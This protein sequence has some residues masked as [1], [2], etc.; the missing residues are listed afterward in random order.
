M[1]K[2]LSDLL[3]GL[4][5]EVK[6]E[7]KPVEVSGLAYDSRVAGSGDLFFCVK[8][9]RDDGHRYLPD[10]ERNGAVAS[11]VE[12]FVDGVGIP[13]FRVGDVRLAMSEVSAR[14]YDHPSDALS[15]I[16]I[17]GTKGKTTTTF[18]ME[19]ILRAAGYPS[20]LIGTIAYRVGKKLVKA[21]RTTP[22]AVDLQRML[23]DAVESGLKYV[24]MEVS[25][26]S[27][28][29]HR[30][31]SVRFAASLL[32]NLQPEHL[33]FHGSMD[34]YIAAKSKL[35]DLTEGVIVVNRD[36]EYFDAVLKRLGKRSFHTYSLNGKGDVNARVLRM[37]DGGVSLKV[38][39]S[40]GDFEVESPLVGMFNAYNVT[41]AV[42]LS[43]CMGVPVESVVEGVK[44]LSAVP[45][46]MERVD[47]PW[48]WRVIIDYAHTVDSYREL[49]SAV[50]SF[51]SG[52]VISVFG[53][54]GN[55][56]PRHRPAMG[57]LS[58]QVADFVVITSD[59]PRWEEPSEITRAIEQGC[60]EAGGKGRYAV[61]VDR[62][63]AI[64]YA[65]QMARKG[66][67]VVVSGK[68]H[69]DYIL[70]KGKYYPYSDRDVVNR[71]LREMGAE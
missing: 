23:H 11:V 13:Q 45:G 28:A 43:L 10:A 22:E 54:G 61:I 7:P 3:R 8:G 33:D 40:G 9:F 57:R 38:E 31:A 69:E 25:S 42:S 29:L 62:Q 70:V 34:E 35:F 37:D 5:L 50:R 41:A 6:G 65:M 51:T 53:L 24:V 55:R 26:H 58:V 16:G 68:G 71:V 47:T 64:R 44:V 67:S 46:R 32:T 36:S 1:K 30:V 60:I 4:Y 59:N 49:M 56:D 39:Y 12:R 48:G 21:H 18:L 15:V 19:S 17:T 2:R 63:E 14:F 66:D 20:G 52:R 27:L